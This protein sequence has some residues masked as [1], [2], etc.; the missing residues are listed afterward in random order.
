MK[1]AIFVLI[2]ILIFSTGVFGQNTGPLDLVVLL[3]TSVSMSNSHWETSDYLIGPFLREFLRLGDTFHLIS[4]S[5]TPN[6]EIS[7]RVEGLGDIE[8]V[9]TRLLLQFPLAPVAN[10]SASLSFAENFIGT[11]PAGRARQVVLISD[12]VFN[13]IGSFGVVTILYP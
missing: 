10:I 3:D 7:R 5:E 11:L 12:G 8:T 6:L 13:I 1:K 9:I 4:I 2:L